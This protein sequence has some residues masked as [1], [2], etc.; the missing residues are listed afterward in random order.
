M[1]LNDILS[2]KISIKMDP[3][4]NKE[5]TK[6]YLGKLYFQKADY[7]KAIRIYEQGLLINPQSII[8]IYEIG[9]TY[10]KLKKHKKALKYW[11]RLLRIAPHSFLANEVSQRL[12][13]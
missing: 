7:Q 1:I 4:T 11:R 9:L 5:D 6:Y 12:K 13:S 8:L 10:S 2:K 3:I